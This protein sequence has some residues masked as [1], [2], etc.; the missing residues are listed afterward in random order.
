MATPWKDIKHKL[1]EEK[2][3]QIKRE[4]IEELTRIGLL[5]PVPSSTR[6][7]APQSDPASPPAAPE[8]SR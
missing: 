1:S 6:I 2:R 5:K 7:S 8:S 4:A 3:E